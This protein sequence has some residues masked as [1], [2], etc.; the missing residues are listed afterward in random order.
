MSRKKAP[1]Q[2]KYLL[3]TGGRWGKQAIREGIAAEGAKKKTQTIMG[4]KYN[5]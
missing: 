4:K 1:E 5:L 2:A 3:G